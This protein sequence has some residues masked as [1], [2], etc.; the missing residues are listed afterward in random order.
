M[1][2]YLEAEVLCDDGVAATVE[3]RRPNVLAGRG[4]ATNEWRFYLFAEG[5]YYSLLSS[6]PQQ[7]GNLELGSV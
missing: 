5:G 4:A 3:I 2:G 7:T 6:L 1:R